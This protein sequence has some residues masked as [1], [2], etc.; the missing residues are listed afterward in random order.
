MQRA[1]HFI[2]STAAII[3]DATARHGRRVAFDAGV[4]DRGDS[5]ALATP[6]AISA[7]R[8]ARMLRAR[9]GWIVANLPREDDLAA[10]PALLEADGGGDAWALLETRAPGC[11]SA[12]LIAR[13]ETLS[14]AV[15]AIGETQARTPHLIAARDRAARRAPLRVIDLSSLWAGPLCGAVFAGMG[16]DV[17]KLDS[18]ERPDPTPQSAPA[19]D[20][21]L[22]GAKRRASF[23]LTTAEGRAALLDQVAN[24]DILITSARARALAN[25]GLAPERILAGNPSLIWVAITGHSWSSARVAFGD[26]A[27]ASGGLVDWR[28]DAPHF[29]G[30]AIADPLTGLAAAAA[31]LHALDTRVSGFID[32]SLAH[33]AAHVASLKP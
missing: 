30:D 17:L 4:L 6:G 29:L 15:A 14:L 18:A 7:N 5:I 21:R 22:N 8:S 28:A 26:D 16:A 1:L 12:D 13:A 25:L 24:A 20:G 11:A 23:A 32:A 27:A 10:I 9:D 31:A 33:T 3:A 19:L 2:E